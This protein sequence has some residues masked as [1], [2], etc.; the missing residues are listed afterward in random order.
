M[1]FIR[2]EPFDLAVAEASMAAPDWRLYRE[3]MELGAEA[4]D[5]IAQY[6]VAFWYLHGHEDLG[7]EEG[8]YR[9]AVRWLKPAARSFAPAMVE[10]GLCL[11]YARGIRRDRKAAAA[12]FQRAA[13][14]GSLR[15]KT[16]VAFI[17]EEGQGV[18]RSAAKARN[19][20]RQV[21]PLAERFWQLERQYNAHHASATTTDDA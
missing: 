14:G 8:R 13:R 19:A 11:Y 7:I 4:G 1:E 18:P 6:A 10:L 2:T 9:E 20:E 16:L 12:L 5:P 17:H 21:A 15:G 3:L